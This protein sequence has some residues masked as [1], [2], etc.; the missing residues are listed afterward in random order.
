MYCFVLRMYSF[1]CT[2]LYWEC[3]HSYVLFCTDLWTHF[4]FFV[5][6]R[7]VLCY[8]YGTPFR[9]ID[10]RMV[11]RQSTAETGR[12]RPSII[13]T[14]AETWGKNSSRGGHT[15]IEIVV[16]LF[17]QLARCYYNACHLFM[18]IDWLQT[19]V[20]H[21]IVRFTRLCVWCKR[22]IQDF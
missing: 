3:T 12:S 20:E 19:S 13:R 1:I 16:S 17:H 15:N 18:K 9:W 21:K 4:Y 6:T 11:W 8:L 14:E 2:V 5:G 7:V 22:N 10:I